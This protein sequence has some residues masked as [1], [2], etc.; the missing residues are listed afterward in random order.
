[1]EDQ[2]RIFQYHRYSKCYQP[3]PNTS[4]ENYA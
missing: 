1:M 2:D 4:F 3:V